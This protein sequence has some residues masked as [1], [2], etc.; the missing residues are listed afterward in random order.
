M[1]WWDHH[2]GVEIGEGK[3][4][5]TLPFPVLIRNG[6]SFLFWAGAMGK[7]K[8]ITVFE[9]QISSWLLPLHYLT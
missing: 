9:C 2:R 8:G 1:F 4:K 5:E 3:R 6:L 7:D